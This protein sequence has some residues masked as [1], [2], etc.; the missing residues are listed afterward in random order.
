MVC[1]G[2]AFKGVLGMVTKESWHF[3][4]NEWTDKVTESR[5]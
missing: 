4:L 2:T 1:Y 5:P 3:F